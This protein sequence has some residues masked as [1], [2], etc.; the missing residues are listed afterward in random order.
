MHIVQHSGERWFPR[1]HREVIQYSRHYAVELFGGDI[2]EEEEGGDDEE[3]ED[4]DQGPEPH[5]QDAPE[6]PP[7]QEEP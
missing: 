6:A 1:A 4:D 5:E 2:A 3:A 7:Y